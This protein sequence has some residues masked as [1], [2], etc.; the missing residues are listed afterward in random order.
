MKRNVLI[1]E[2]LQV[3]REFLTKI[4][5]D[6]D[7]D[8]C[9]YPCGT[10]EEACNCMLKRKIDLF[11]LDIVLNPDEV[12]DFSGIRFADFVRG[13]EQYLAA[14]IIFVTSLAGLEI[15]L[16]KK[17]HCFDYIEKP[18]SEERVKRVVKDALRK[19]NV[20][21]PEDAVL[22]VRKDRVS[23]PIRE[24]DIVYLES[25]RKILSIHKTDDTLEIP[26]LSL[27]YFLKEIGTQKFLMPTKG[28]AINSRYIEYVDSG[29][30]YVKM[31]GVDQLIELGSRMKKS[32]LKEME[33]L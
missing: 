31:K 29:N 7:E 30:S 19:L 23:Y 25:R 22:Y 10:V 8:I 18:I 21:K 5:S 9:V 32:F 16:M 17:V 20:K 4:V 28:V 11:L 27:K 12:G 1:L 33:E 2:D 24:K 3:A 6:C 26:N 15:D 14:E 13:H